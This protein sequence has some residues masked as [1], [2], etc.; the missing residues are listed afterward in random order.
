MAAAPS[1]DITTVYASRKKYVEG[2]VAMVKALHIDGVTWVTHARARRD[3]RS[4][5]L[6]E[7]RAI[8]P[9]IS[10]RIVCSPRFDYESPI[11]NG[12]PLADQYVQ[13]INETTDALHAEIPGSQTS[14]CVACAL[15]AVA[16]AARPTAS[17]YC[18]TRNN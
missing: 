5:Y 18:H 11:P 10:K 4:K 12:S 17:A 6:S 9:S 8:W 13:V 15:L 1:F 16:R 2:I 7:S 3:I 14:V